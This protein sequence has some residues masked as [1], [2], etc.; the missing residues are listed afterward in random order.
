ML[1]S[2]FFLEFFLFQPLNVDGKFYRLLY[3]K[4]NII[5]GWAQNIRAPLNLG[6]MIC[7]ADPDI[8][9]LTSK[10]LVETENYS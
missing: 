4:D 7:S 6:T 3:H 1:N 9:P 2:S 10:I 5:R 8:E